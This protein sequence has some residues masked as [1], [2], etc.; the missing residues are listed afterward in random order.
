MLGGLRRHL[1]ASSLRVEASTV[2]EALAATAA[3]G[4]E[5]VAALLFGAEVGPEGRGMQ[6]D[7]RVLVN[8]R[9]ILFLDGLDT[10]L[11]EDDTVTIHF[12]GARGYPGG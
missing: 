3:R 9:S 10:E 5:P 8:G 1:G 2:R 4:G 6:E 7:L 12:A 11:A